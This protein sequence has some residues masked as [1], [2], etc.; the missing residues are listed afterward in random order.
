M[1]LEVKPKVALHNE[2]DI[3]VRNIKTGEVKKFKAYNI[4]LDSQLT[5]FASLSTVAVGEIH[6]GS[7]TGTL[8][9]SRTSLFNLVRRRA[10]TDVDA[11]LDPAI[12]TGWQKKSIT[13]TPAEDVGVSFTEVGLGRNTDTGLRTHAFIEDS[14]GNPISIGP[15]TDTEEIT[16]YATWYYKLL[17]DNVDGMVY[18]GDKT[19]GNGSTQN[20]LI[21]MMMVLRNDNTAPVANQSYVRLSTGTSRKETIPWKDGVVERKAYRYL[22]PQKT[23]GGSVVGFSR[24]YTAETRF[25]SNEANGNITELCFDLSNNTDA[26]V[27]RLP[28]CRILVRDLPASIWDGVTFADKQIGTGDGVVTGFDTPHGLIEDLVVKANG[29]VKTEGT[30]Y[31]EFS[32]PK[33]TVIDAHD[34]TTAQSDQVSVDSGSVTRPEAIFSGAVA[35]SWTTAAIMGENSSA[36]IDLGEARKWGL[37]AINVYNTDPSTSRISDDFDVLISS[38]NTNWTAIGQNLSAGSGSGWTGEINF[39]TTPSNIF[40][41]IKIVNN[42]TKNWEISETRLITKKNQIEFNSPVS[43]GDPVTAT[44]KVREYIPKADTF[45]LDISGPTITF[46]Y[47]NPV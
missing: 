40:R 18:V 3:H 9:T 12:Y 4:V 11:G 16:F 17:G 24:K 35:G 44:Y 5:A 8:D 23:I 19:A 21:R 43:A 6:I 7:G 25:E 33:N 13:I 42:S 46:G 2:F 37:G 29:V 28:L 22:A 20:A 15:K 45:F 39:N 14:E 1:K 32:H 27:I 34:T 47:E 36:V 31:V 41:Y 10:Y 26:T 38:D 30:D